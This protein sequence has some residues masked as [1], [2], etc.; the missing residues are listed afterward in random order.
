VKVEVMLKD[1]G[2]KKITLNRMSHMSIFLH[3]QGQN[4]GENV[5]ELEDHVG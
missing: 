3:I 4:Y 1:V 2:A 5:Y